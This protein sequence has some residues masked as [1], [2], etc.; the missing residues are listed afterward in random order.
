MQVLKKWATLLMACLLLGF[1][2]FFPEPHIVGKIKWIAGGAKGM[3][4]MDW[5]D[6]AMH[7]IP[8]VMV[9]VVLFMA[10]V[11]KPKQDYGK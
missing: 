8:L 7:G 11:Q 1:A 9:V 5:F 3:Q 2:P 4:L 10:I 6:V